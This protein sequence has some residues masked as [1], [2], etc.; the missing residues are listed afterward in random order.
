MRTLWFLP[1]RLPFL[2]ASNMEESVGPRGRK[3]LF[4][5]L[6]ENKVQPTPRLAQK[7]Y[8]C[9]VCRACAV[10]C[11]QGIDISEVSVHARHKII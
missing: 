3:T 2:E 5:S 10:K 4:L 6:F 7:F 11:P 8:M 1:F 9:G